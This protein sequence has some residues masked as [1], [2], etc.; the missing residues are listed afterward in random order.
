[1]DDTERRPVGRP[2]SLTDERVADAIIAC[3]FTDLKAVDVAE[4]LSV[5]PA[6]L[7]RHVSGH[8][9][10]VN[11][12]VSRLVATTVW[13]ALDGDRWREYLESVTWTLWNLVRSHPGL[14]TASPAVGITNPELMSLYSGICLDLIGAGFAPADAGLAVDFVL[15]LAIDSLKMRETLASQAAAD[16]AVE[17]WYRNLD[18][19]LAEAMRESMHGD[20][21]AWFGRKLEVA[22]DGIE[23]VLRR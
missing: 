22:L 5:N 14:A 9:E 16:P 10:M 12:A 1:M 4:R 23:H 19:D 8:T 18:A 17:N 2:R 20:P 6:T 11:L 3:G 21:A 7:Y 15:D 13:P